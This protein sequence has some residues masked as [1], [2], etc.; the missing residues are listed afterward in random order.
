LKTACLL[1]FTLCLCG[2][3]AAE[4][5]DINS[6]ALT[7]NSIYQ[8]N[9]AKCHGKTAAGRHFGGPA[10]ISERVSSASIDDLRAIINNGKARMPKF[11]GK[12]ASVDVDQLL[13][14]IK[15]ANQK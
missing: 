8:K 4:D 14:Q 5:R 13:M 15:G 10:L 6:S 11:A 1:I 9:C 12:L 7:S 2:T 3:I